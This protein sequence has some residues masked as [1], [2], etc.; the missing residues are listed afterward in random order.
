MI[1]LAVVH[2]VIFRT[3]IKHLYN[4]AKYEK[5]LEN[6]KKIEKENEPILSLNINLTNLFYHKEKATAS[7]YF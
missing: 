4:S 6:I 3:V 7:R 1:D 2:Y 5:S